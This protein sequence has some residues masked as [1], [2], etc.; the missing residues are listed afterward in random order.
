MVQYDELM[1]VYPFTPA[2]Y[3]LQASPASRG[4]SCDNVSETS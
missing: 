2:G 3:S 4:P 1:G